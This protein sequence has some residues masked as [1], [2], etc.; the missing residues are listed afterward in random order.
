[1]LSDLSDV[2]V[3]GALEQVVPVDL[4]HPPLNVD[5]PFTIEAGSQEVVKYLN[6][7]KANYTD[8]VN[9]LFSLDWSYIVNSD[10]NVAIANFYSMISEAIRTYVPLVTIR[11]TSYPKWFSPEL[12]QRVLEKKIAHKR[13]K[14]SQKSS[15]L[16]TFKSLR[17]ICSRLRNNC[18]NSYIAK[19][20]D[21][22]VDSK[23]LWKFRNS[24]NSSDN[25]Y[26]NPMYLG[27][28]VARSGG[29]IVG[30]FSD[31]FGD[32]YVADDSRGT[33]SSNVG[34]G[35]MDI[36]R[37]VLTLSTV[38]RALKKL[39]IDKSAGPDGVPPL[40]LKNC[41]IALAIPITFLFNSSL[42]CGVFPSLW[43]T[44]NITPIF[45]KGDKADIANYRPI[46]IQNTIA[47]LFESLVLEHFMP[48][49][50][51]IIK[52][53]QHGFL[54][55]KSTL[56]N[57]ALYEHY[58]SE[59]LTHKVQVDS[60]YTDFQKAFDKVS[61]RI[62]LDKLQAIGVEGSLLQWFATYLSDRRLRVKIRDYIS[63]EFIATS[64]LPQGS[65]F[66]PIL[67]L[68]FIN[69]ITDNLSG[70]EFL[71]F[72]DDLK[73]YNRIGSM[74]DCLVLQAAL[75]GL[76]IWCQ[77]NRLPLNIDKCQYIRFSRN[78]S[79]IQ[80]SYSIDGRNLE[81]VEEIRDLGVLFDSKLSFKN[82][83]TG[84]RN[85]A[86]KSLGFML[87]TVSGFK[88]I[89]SLKLLYMSTVRTI[90]DFNSPI[91]SPNYAVHVDGLEKVQRKFLRHVNYLLGISREHLN[92]DYLYT[93]TG[94]TPLQVRRTF[95]D[96]VFL[97]K[98]LN[99]SYDSP[100]LLQNINIRIPL[101]DTRSM[102]LFHVD[103]HLT[104]YTRNTVFPRLHASGNRYLGSI[105]IF[106][107]SMAQFKLQ[108]ERAVRDL[109]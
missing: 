55:G 32:V 100:E 79:P 50:I 30:L 15:D 57:L 102:D 87:R 36:G 41:V 60:V 17:D 7:K 44:G 96:L 34:G 23:S 26:P 71:L 14:Q 85:R 91:W 19:A 65:H 80:F 62:L 22:T 97:Y 33:S 92:Y 38:E 1:V 6:F 28:R 12:K 53:P 104:N 47:K 20:E 46:C 61:H 16:E 78:K 18:Y 10:I 39:N 74:E 109:N 89:A 56:T 35:C 81:R 49:V 45:K 64:G 42:E 8:I 59:N 3:T 66:G 21:R 103:T 27:N 106:N 51:K 13:F 68:I 86:M 88:S 82:H 101:R 43:K 40:F 73:V 52:S 94:L 83:I 84:I 48:H 77:L 24:L 29:D 37:C 4:Y 70:V 54:P 75:D 2:R 93:H 63:D 31:F 5:A 90:L 67:F 98:I 69:D 105:D 107:T 76:S 11:P 95:F 99:Y 72:A 58:I 108:M 25:N 9:Y